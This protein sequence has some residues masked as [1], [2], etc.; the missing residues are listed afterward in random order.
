MPFSIADLFGG[1]TTTAMQGPTPPPNYA[2]T[3]MNNPELMKARAWEALGGFGNAMLAAS[4]PSSTPR[5]FGD[6]AASGL[7]GV[8][9]GAANAEDKYLKRALL[10]SQL[11]T[12]E[13]ERKRQKAFTDLVNGAQAPTTTAV[14]AAPA[15]QP[16]PL[17]GAAGAIAGIESG[18]RYDAIGP[19]ANDKGNRAYG[20]YQVMDFNIPTWTQE[21]LGKPMS[22]QEFLQNPQAQDAVFQ[23][24]FGEYTKKHGSPE[25]ASRAW[26]AG[27]GGMN[28]PNAKDVL[29]TTVQGYGNKFAQA[30]GP[31]ATGPQTAQPPGAP[32]VQMAQAQIPGA[33]V[34]QGDAVPP[35]DASGTPL[36]P[37]QTQ[38][39]PGTAQTL[40]DVVNTLTPA[41]RALLGTMKA[42]EGMQFLLQQ[43]MPN[44]QSVYNTQTGQVEFAPKNLI[45]RDPRLVPVDAAKLQMEGDKLKLQKQKT[46]SDLR[47]ADVILD[48]Q[49]R[50]IV[51]PTLLDAKK[52]VS[53]AQGTDPG[54]KITVELAQDAI[55]RNTDYQK[56]GLSAQSAVTKLGT[57]QNLLD[58]IA[59]NKFKGT[60]SEI[61][62]AAKAAGMDLT[63][64][65]VT[66]DVGPT[67]AAAA[68]T[69]LMSL[70]NRKEMPGPMSDGDRSFLTAAQA[71]ITKD[72]AGNR[73]LIDIQKG[74]AQRRVDI[75]K[76]SR[77]YIKSPEFKTNPAGL[78]DYIQSKLEGKNYYNHDLIKQSAAPA[79]AI[80]APPAGFTSQG[81]ARPS[82]IPA[83]PAGFRPIP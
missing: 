19:A 77:E 38:A 76:A 75:A 67:Q 34:P 30:Y 32:P 17:G 31:G 66:D 40:K 41:Q 73:I 13:D 14:G 11:Q 70:E 65:G 49:G 15:G 7:Y 33:G 64:L 48:G 1:G 59:T 16:A 37:Q 4:G 5:G 21:V 83:P 26:F 63:A 74:D 12:A 22:P 68:L 62:A 35:A 36:P 61:K 82:G 52:G 58:Q 80:P 72:P 60:T 29:G 71:S 45:G 20:K 50:P 51:N 25:A 43:A 54:S 24:K 42:G 9:Q 56:E 81:G 2:S 8:G 47:N 69:S 57:V 6:V 39:M 53:A 10:G 23:A 78:D 46:E 55:K 28:N 3:I 27:E 44:H 18:G 79:G